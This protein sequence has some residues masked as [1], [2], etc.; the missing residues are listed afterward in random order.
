MDL[1]D[2]LEGL[3]NQHFEGFKESERQPFSE[4]IMS[5]DMADS[6]SFVNIDYENG[7]HTHKAKQMMKSV[8]NENVQSKS[9]INM[10][11]PESPGYIDISV[12]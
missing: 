3:N 8:R 11:S 2:R 5:Y 9:I 7:E 10:D 12:N 6:Q 4:T 1:H